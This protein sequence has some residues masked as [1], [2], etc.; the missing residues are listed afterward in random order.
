MK[1]DASQ[2]KLSRLKHSSLTISTNKLEFLSQHIDNTIMSNIKSSI[3]YF[4]SFSSLL[5][6]C[7][8]LQG[9]GKVN[10]S[11][12]MDKDIYGSEITGSAAFLAARVVL[13]NQ[14]FSCHSAWSAYTET[15]YVSSGRVV[16]GN[17][18]SSTLYTSIKGNDSGTTGTMP[19]NGSTLSSGELLLIKSWIQAM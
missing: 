19:A 6:A 15:D 16:A 14:C 12:S 4:C 8:L 18:N 5:L 3:Q 13:A 9:C 7:V 10:N 11:S 17:P 1:L 2:A